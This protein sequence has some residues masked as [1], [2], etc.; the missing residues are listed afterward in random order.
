MNIY[1]KFALGLVMVLISSACLREAYAHGCGPGLK[2]KVGERGTIVIKADVEEDKPSVYGI[3]EYPNPEIAAV[4][5]EESALHF[6][7]TFKEAKWVILGLKPGKTTVKATWY[8]EP[9]DVGDECVFE[10]EVVPEEDAQPT[11]ALN[12][13]N[14]A[15]TADP[16]NT[17]TGEFIH[18]EDPDI[19]LGGPMNVSF[20]RYYASG[21][22]R[23]SF[24]QDIMGQNWSHNYDFQ[25]INSDNFTD[26]LFPGGEIVSFQKLDD[27][28]WKRESHPQTDFRLRQSE[29]GEWLLADPGSS[30]VY[31]FNAD[32]N[33]EHVTDGKGNELMLTYEAG[34]MTTVA[35]NF[36]RRLNFIYS[37][38]HQLTEVSDGVR[39]VNFQ[40]IGEYLM[41]VTDVLGGKTTYDYDF[42][43]P[44]LAL[45]TKIT[46]P[47]EN[48]PLTMTY[49]DSGRVTG[50]TTADNGNY[51]YSYAPGQVSIT[52][53]LGRIQTH[54]YDS[55]GNLL[56]IDF[57]EGIKKNYDYSDTGRKSTS[58]FRNGAQLELK[59]DPVTG[60]PVEV[61]TPDGLKQSATYGSYSLLGFE[62]PAI[63]SLSTSGGTSQFYGYDSAGRLVSF[64]DPIGNRSQYTY[65]NLGRL[66]EILHPDDSSD[67]FIYNDAG[68]IESWQD[69]T[70]ITNEYAYDEF[71]RLVSVKEAGVLTLQL[72]YDA[73][74]RIIS[75]TD[76]SGLSALMQYD[77]NGNLVKYTGLGGASISYT[78]DDMDRL[79]SI[80][81]PG[82]YT[83]SA[84]YN[85][86]GKPVRIVD[87][88]DGEIMIEYDRFNYPAAY[89][90][91]TGQRWE[92]KY[93]PSGDLVSTKS[94][95]GRV[96]NILR[97]WEGVIRQI[98]IPGRGSYKFEFNENKD[99]SG[100]VDPEG[101]RTSVI[102]NA[103]GKL[104]KFT[105]P[106]GRS[107][108]FQY[109]NRGFLTD[110]TAPGQNIWAFDYDSSGNLISTT[111]PSGNHESRSYDG[112]G[113][114]TDIAYPELNNAISIGYA[115]EGNISS[116]SSPGD[117][118]IVLNPATPDG[119]ISGN[120]ISLKISP[121]NGRIIENNGINVSY[122]SEFRLSTLTFD[123]N[124]NIQYLYNSSGRLVKISDWAGHE[125]EFAY[126]NAG[127]LTLI[128]R[129]SG[130][131][132]GIG[133][134]ENGLPG[135][136]T[137]TRNNV[138][139]SDIVI[140][141]NSK[142]F[143]ESVR[144]DPLHIPEFEVK[145]QSWTYDSSS[146]TAGMTWDS[147]GRLIS[148][149][150]RIFQWDTA[151]RL[152]S[153]IN[154]QN[155]TSWN[156]DSEGNPV[157]LTTGDSTVNMVW[158]YSL[159]MPALHSMVNDT[160][161]QSGVVFIYTPAGYLLYAVDTATGERMDY[162]FDEKGNT[163][164]LL[165]QNG[166]I[167]AHYSYDPY[168]RIFTH[169]ESVSLP[170]KFQGQIGHFT[171]PASGNL[172]RMKARVY[173]PDMGRFL[174]P[175]PVRRFT[176]AR[177]ANPYVYTR[178]NPINFRDPDGRDA[179][180]LQTSSIHTEIVVDIYDAAGNH[181]GYAQFDF[182]PVGSAFRYSNQGAVKGVFY[183]NF[184]D[185]PKNK[186]LL[187]M[188]RLTGTQAQDIRLLNK[189]LEMQGFDNSKFNYSGA[190]I[191]D[192]MSRKDTT[193]DIRACLMQKMGFTSTRSWIDFLNGDLQT[194]GDYSLVPGKS[195][196]CNQ[197]VNEMLGT[198]FGAN[199][200]DTVTLLPGELILK[201]GAF[202]GLGEG[203]LAWAVIHG[204]N[205]NP[206]NRLGIEIG[207]A[208]L[209]IFDSIF[210]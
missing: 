202:Q 21:M 91:E 45:L 108:E 135:R 101:K 29:D 132:S 158:N 166:D 3:K 74:D 5:P 48:V 75:A 119:Q 139:I 47:E 105:D 187:G 80:S 42:S 113:R 125:T 28:A 43:R 150:T 184:R 157:S 194:Y 162:I 85:K 94:P 122:D 51:I 90:D 153:L 149:G 10:I 89:I 88:L 106:E 49:D 174:T 59:H 144:R 145:N 102:Y 25:L 128:D 40:H 76:E 131:D 142:G 143:I 155:T 31:R 84:E 16:V 103:I 71:R 176:G 46:R 195:R 27:G 120:N 55:N 98:D 115:P 124:R 123:G 86:I 154:G 137:T 209:A 60:E 114:L 92:Q 156:Y 2:L 182:N 67:K 191:R 196:Y 72:Q 4:L 192:F 199:W 22:S 33:L 11:S 180:I 57:G 207:S 54:Q 39:H 96:M 68:E 82:E 81:G 151:N 168:G 99:P 95:D 201:A 87:S 1:R 9:N 62:F 83:R 30:M 197:F 13:A 193:P 56:S 32:G 175:D 210:E 50:Q 204:N 163:N 36:G 97:D 118:S 186:N 37:G 14:S 70:G 38:F 164:Y 179:Y 189:L 20:R 26:I 170:F 8:Y 112:R 117:F 146:R 177:L 134:D 78:Y 109:N 53:P 7:Q 167:L 104:T 171:H 69:P 152:T 63:T 138:I 208:G 19:V 17:F 121:E 129:D 200:P 198:F 61:T 110:L 111:D 6:Q 18:Y 203:T 185:Y 41:Q 178:N 173:D 161:I 190:Q 181:A 133:Y 206:L 205:I 165:S 127:R 147:R 136:Y 44:Q 58:Q 73:K 159:G 107:L 15:A 64:T 183:D 188:V 23:N 93:S 148:D 35:D 66:V 12:H 77:K 24:T 172:I 52:D 116:L 160:S 169:Q 79:I 141:R 100:A 34:V 140:S 65:D 126:D 130:T